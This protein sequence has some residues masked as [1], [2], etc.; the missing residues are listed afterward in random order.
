MEKIFE[1]L[2][3]N[4]Q[5]L[6]L[7]TK[8]NG[9]AQLIKDGTPAIYNT[10][11]ELQNITTSDY[12]SGVTFFLAA[13]EMDLNDDI[14]QIVACD[15]MV[16]ITYPI[17]LFAITKKGTGGDDS[18]NYEGDLALS[19]MKAVLINN[20]KSLRQELKLSVLKTA[21]KGLSTNTTENLKSINMKDSHNLSCVAIKVDIIAEG[22]INCINLLSCLVPA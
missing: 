16:R 5:S 4:L 18:A 10:K 21:M 20:P 15:R 7:F 1:Q 19:L 11:G 6:G 2:I 3:A 22:A 13:G 9:L 12:T 17:T 8:V 14:P